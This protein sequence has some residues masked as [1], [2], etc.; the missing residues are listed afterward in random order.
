M[1]EDAMTTVIVT[2]G[3]RE[4]VYRIVDGQAGDERS[5]STPAFTSCAR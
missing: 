1:K 3:E 4:L 2:E 5:S